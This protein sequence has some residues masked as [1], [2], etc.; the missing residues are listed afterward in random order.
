MYNSHIPPPLAVYLPPLDNKPKVCWNSSHKVRQGYSD[1]GVIVTICYT[2]E[3][4]GK[5]SLWRMIGWP[6]W[7][8]LDRRVS[9]FFD[10]TTGY[11]RASLQE[12][13]KIYSRVRTMLIKRLCLQYRQRYSSSSTGTIHLY[14]SSHACA[15]VQVAVSREWRYRRPS[16]PNGKKL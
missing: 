6:L 1:S 4:A 9:S 5:F 15:V 11:S 8:D 10:V 7:V 2:I 14:G 12:R 13:L 3:G 16:K